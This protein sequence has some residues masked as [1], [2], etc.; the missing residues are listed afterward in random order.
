MRKTRKLV[1]LN[2]AKQYTG[3]ALFHINTLQQRQKWRNQ[4]ANIHV[5]TLVLV[6]NP[7]LPPCKWDLGRVTQCHPGSDGLTRVM[8]IRIATSEFKRPIVKLCVLPIDTH[9]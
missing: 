5:G 2:S 3:G 8:T 9:V 6:K 4:Q 7:L 1:D